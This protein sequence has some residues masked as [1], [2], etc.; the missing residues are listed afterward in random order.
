MAIDVFTVCPVCFENLLTALLQLLVQTQRNIGY[1]L[2]W[3]FLS[4][5]SSLH[6][7]KAFSKFT[8][9]E[10]ETNQIIAFQNFINQ[11][12]ILLQYNTSIIKIYVTYKMQCI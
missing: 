12:Y 4:F 10:Y 11:K 1:Y 9:N 7:P 6:P 8:I 2:S 3:V 5:P